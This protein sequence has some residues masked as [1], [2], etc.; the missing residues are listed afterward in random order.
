VL[1]DSLSALQAID[2]YNSNHPIVLEIQ[3]WLIRFA[4]RHKYV[5]LCW[6][7]GHCGIHGNDRADLE[8][9]RAAVMETRNQPTISIP[10]RDYHHT[11]KDAMRSLWADQWRNCARPNKLHSIKTTIRPWPSAANRRR[12]AEI[13]LCRL[14]IGHTWITHHHLMEKTPA[15]YCLDCIVPLTVIH[16]I[17]ECPTWDQQRF[18]HFPHARQLDPDAR[19]KLMIAESPPE[20]YST[21]PLLRYLT[22]ILLLSKI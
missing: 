10:Y 16:I 5:Q 14:R 2:K 4:S 19:I 20:P 17:A 7:P 21:E 13:V 22:D 15:P 1:S 3:R 11:I 6:V 9:R 8:A 12:R 18:Q